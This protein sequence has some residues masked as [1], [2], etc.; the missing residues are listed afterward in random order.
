M[1]TMLQEEWNT[2]WKNLNFDHQYLSST[3]IGED[4][5]LTAYAELGKPGEYPGVEF[6]CIDYLDNFHNPHNYINPNLLNDGWLTREA[7]EKIE[8]F[9]KQQLATTTYLGPDNILLKTINVDT[10]IGG[11]DPHYAI[12]MTVPYD[13]EGTIEDVF[14]TYINPFYACIKNVTDPGTFN[15]PYIF[16]VV[17]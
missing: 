7:I 15:S 1:D 17:Q 10:G 8:T 9:Y 12:T 6:G 16:S 11:D 4:K 13:T 5:L 2:P 3:E 14:N